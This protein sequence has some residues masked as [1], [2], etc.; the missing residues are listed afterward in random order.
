[1]VSTK[2]IKLVA[3]LRYTG[4][5]PE[6]VEKISRGKARYHYEIQEDEWQQLQK[7]FDR[8]EFLKFAQC[9]DAVIDLAY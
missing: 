8:S 4:T 3:W 2:N 1:M 6:K 5:H 9:L 7:E